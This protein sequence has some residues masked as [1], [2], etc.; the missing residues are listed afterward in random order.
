[1]QNPTLTKT[2]LH[3]SEPIVTPLAR[4][5][6]AFRIEFANRYAL[7]GTTPKGGYEVRYNEQQNEIRTTFL[8]RGESPLER[9]QLLTRGPADAYDPVRIVDAIGRNE[10]ELPWVQ[11]ST[12]PATGRRTVTVLPFGDAPESPRVLVSTSASTGFISIH[13]ESARDLSPAEA[14][15][16]AGALAKAADLAAS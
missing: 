14:R 12:D 6:P 11:R 7:R 15:L 16:V 13:V 8:A 5:L 2:Q 9:I 1:M 10:E 3:V 4:R